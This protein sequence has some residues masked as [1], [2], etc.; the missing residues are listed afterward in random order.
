M[1]FKNDQKGKGDK[2][3]S[4]KN[5]LPMNNNPNKSI[6]TISKHASTK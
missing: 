4:N 5:T 6:A 3:D 2:K 1:D